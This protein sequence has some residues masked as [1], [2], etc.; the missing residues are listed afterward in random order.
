M[1][2]GPD[3]E[4]ETREWIDGI[5]ASTES[6]LW[7]I[8]ANIGSFS[9]YAATRGISVVAV[10][11]IPENLLLLSRNVNINGVQNLCTLLPIAL[12][13]RDQVE[14]MTQSSLEFGCA[15]NGFGTNE[16]FRGGTRQTAALS[17]RI[18][19]LTIDSAIE[20][21]GL[22]SP[23]FIK[24]DVDGIDDEILYGAKYSLSRVNG[25]CC[26]TKFDEAR[27]QRLVEF[28][29]GAGLRLTHRSQRNSFFARN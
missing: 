27:V 21:F 18:P 8:G 28:L 5:A 15:G 16:M 20:K 25:V 14:I 19:G 1:L 24:I 26:E 22:P 17:F 7:D 3:R 10:E 9:I 23:R 12:S 4:P 11:P 29:A 13:G 2:E 6:W